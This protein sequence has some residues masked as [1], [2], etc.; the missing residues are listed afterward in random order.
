MGR[1]PCVRNLPY[2]ATEEVLGT[3]F[4][5]HGKVES[6]KLIT[7]S[8]KGQGIGFGFTETG[9]EAEANAIVTAFSGVEVDGRAIKVIDAKPPSKKTRS[10]R[11]GFGGGSKW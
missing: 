7:D 4:S 2:S 3:K 5:A 8:D 11:G 9:S 10:D 6:V 1:K